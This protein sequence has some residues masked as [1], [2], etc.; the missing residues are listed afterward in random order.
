MLPFLTDWRLEPYRSTYTV[1]IK[2]ADKAVHAMDVKDLINK[3][4]SLGY[5]VAETSKE[6]IEKLVDDL[7]KKGEISRA[8]STGFVNE[9][10]RK[11]ED[12]QNRMKSAIRDGVK[13][14]IA[15]LQL[16]T[17][18]DIERIERKLDAL[19]AEKHGS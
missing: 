16:A 14:V 1:V 13:S 11:S 5:G 17:K 10:V 4:I 2:K 12:A 3:A 15:E 18:E 9:L 19:I 8:E 7:V 6:Q